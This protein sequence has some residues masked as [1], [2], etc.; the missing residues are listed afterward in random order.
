MAAKSKSAKL[1]SGAAYSKLR[2]M[3][4]SGEGDTAFDAGKLGKMAARSTTV[5][6]SFELDKVYGTQALISKDARDNGKGEFTV[7]VKDGALVVTLEDGAHSHYLKVPELILDD[8]QPYHLAVSMG[9][10]G[11]M[12]WLDGTLVAAEPEAKTGLQANDESLVIGGTRAWTDPDRDAHSLIDGTISDVMI[13]D[14]QLGR[15]K[16]LKLA[17]AADRDIGKAATMASD[18]A[19]LAPLLLQLHHASETLTGILAGHGVSAHGHLHG[20]L[21]MASGKSGRDTLSGTRADDGLD[22]RG[23]HDTIDGKA[24]DDL[25]QGGYGNDRLDGGK[26]RDILDGGHGEDTLKGGAGRDLLIS[27]ADG[28]EGR[29]AR[30][31]GRDE[32]DPYNELTKGKLYPDQPIPADD[33][34]IGGKGADVFY[35]QTLINAKER[36]IEEHTRSDGTINWHGVAGEN[37]KLHDHWVDVMGRDVIMDFDRGEGDRIMIEGHTTEIASI[38]YGDANGDGVM[39]HSVIALYSDQG[40]GGGAHNDDKLG[41]I[42]V[43]GDLVKHSDIEHSSKPAYGIV[44]KINEKDEALA[45]ETKGKDTG[46]IKAPKELPERADYAADGAKPVF[47]AAGTHSFTAEERAPLVFEHT[48]ALDLRKGTIAFSFEAER[49]EGYQTLISKDAKDYGKGGHLSVSLNEEGDLQIRIQDR[50][51]SYH[52]EVE[53]AVKTGTRYDLALSFGPEGLQVYLNGARVAYD[54]EVKVNW[55]SNTEALVVGASGMGNTPGETDRIYNHFN[56]E[57]ED[58]RIFGKELTGRDIFGE[59]PK[60]DFASFSG[61]ARSYSFDVDGTGKLT[62]SKGKSETLVKKSVMFVEFADFTARTDDF[63]FGTGR[64]DSLLGS[65]TADALLGRGGDDRLYGNGNDDLLVGGRGND[66]GHGGSGDDQLLGEAGDDY[67][68]G[69]DGDDILRGGT[70]D[71]ELKGGDG[72]DRFYG[73]LGD[74]TIYGHSWGEEGRSKRDK[75][76][77]DGE[78]DD[79]DFE[80]VDF[81]NSTRGET[82][83]KLVVTDAASGG[84]DGFYEGEDHLIDIDKLVFSDRTVDM[85]DLL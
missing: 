9:R 69:D 74:D 82:V 1:A 52:L 24:G 84:A 35:F 31:P 64:D 39:D 40:A 79:Y 47:V 55:S 13:F 62:V 71:D 78:F 51:R 37:D 60:G 25:L 6:L 22:G 32:G 61:T 54:A 26:G 58:V 21:R 5:S 66:S 11:L 38:T 56:G 53:D 63:Q 68:T 34:M 28:R 42:T 81:Y 3:T 43:Y 50:E 80:T 10:D 48:E 20:G 17:R 12:I 41:T 15:D 16:I 18:M 33:V 2:D 29:I 75:V 4:F 76:Y 8:G 72:A 23:G 19:E 45:P 59:G 30:D 27:R 14:R 36:Y 49:L 83:R 44:H 67:L 46:R 77:F 85:V 73:G 57:I 7:W 65:D 70:G